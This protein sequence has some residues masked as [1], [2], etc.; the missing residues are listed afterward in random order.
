MARRAWTCRSRCGRGGRRC[1]AAH[2]E[3]RRVEQ[4][5]AAVGELELDVAEDLALALGDVELDLAL[6]HALLGSSMNFFVTAAHF[7]SSARMGA[8]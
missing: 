1:A 6:G 2:V 4:D 7:S 5:L 3:V 8:R